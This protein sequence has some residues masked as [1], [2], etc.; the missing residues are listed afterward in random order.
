MRRILCALLVY[1][2]TTCAS[3]APAYQGMSYTS[4]G[5][6]TLSGSG[7][8][9]SLLNM[10]M[11]GT[12]TVALNFW[13]YQP[14]VTSSAIAPTGSSATIE[15]VEHAIDQIHSLGMKVL[16]KP[17]LDV[18]DG[19]NTWRANVAPTDPDQWFTNYRSYINTF[20]DIAEA[21]GVELLSVGCE[22]NNL[23]N[24]ANDQRWTDAIAD[25]RTHYSGPLTYSANWNGGGIGGGYN[26]IDWW[27]ELDKIGIDAYFPISTTTNPSATQLAASWN[28]LADEI[29]AWRTANH[30]DQR[31]LFTEVGYSSYD[32][33]TM[34]PYA[35]ASGQASD[36]AEQ[37]MAYEALLS[38]M[39]QREWWDGAFWWNWETSPM[40][41]SSTSFTP[42]FKLAQDVLAAHYGGP[43]LPLPSTTWSNDAGGAIG[44]AS[45]WSDGVPNAVFK[46]EFNRGEAV[47]YTVTLNNNRTV[48]QLRVHS[49]TVTFDSNNASNRSLTVDDQHLDDAERAMIVGVDAGDVG[50]VNT[51]TALGSL[52]ARAITLGN[53]AGSTG[54]LNL[55]H[56][57]NRLN[58]TGTDASKTELIVGSAG[59]GTLNVSNGAGVVVTATNANAVIGRDAGSVGTVNLSGAGTSFTTSSVF[60]VG[61]NGQAFLNVSGGATVSALVLAIGATGEVHYDGN[62]TGGLSNSGILQPGNSVGTLVV[63]G[64]YTQLLG[65]RLIIEIASHSSYDQLKIGG[66][67]SLNG[68]FQVA[69]LDEFSPTFGD[70]F[71]VLD[72]PFATGKFAALDLPLLTGSLVWDTSK[73]YTTGVLSIGTNLP[74]DFN[75]DGIVDA[76]DYT[77][78]RDGLDTRY[79]LDDYQDWKDH[80]GQTI[81]DLPG[82]ASANPLAVP[83]PTALEMALAELVAVCLIPLRAGRT[84]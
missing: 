44:T 32:G 67:A 40:P 5:A 50:V 18:N 65:S 41:T 47:S 10:S 71:D 9:Q 19:A 66:S 6:T 2:A 79:G 59:I 60:R 22:F 23:E 69:L 70:T 76:A 39:E 7:S 84:S 56:S 81:A 3:A 57:V 82:W 21:K 80:F 28:S 75:L 34:T 64:T 46:A 42:Q 11:L 14:D 58:V 8:D 31:L 29:D 48:Q 33:T 63:S 1:G 54:T 24:P 13:W 62:L 72:F 17:M 25:I 4:F 35:S 49:N 77:V 37:A 43:G 83:E 36:E 26:A 68:T 16:L 15:S 53:A 20:A 45:N 38:V 61:L 78:W 73:L 52:S 30:P 12:D 74:G 55:T 51:G 27:G